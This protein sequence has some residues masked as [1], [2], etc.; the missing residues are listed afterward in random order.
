TL[1]ELVLRSHG[2]L[3]VVETVLRDEEYMRQVSKGS[4]AGE[5]SLDEL[6]TQRTDDNVRSFL[7][8]IR[9]MT[10]HRLGDVP[11]A[12]RELQAREPVEALRDERVDLEAG[13][14]RPKLTRDGLYNLLIEKVLQLFGHRSLL[15]GL[16]L[17][18]EGAARWNQNRGGKR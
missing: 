2:G 13:I 3:E 7:E 11:A 9:E 8:V 6:P 14:A 15:G 12:R 17:P 10:P 1:G 16:L 18:V 4:H 5:L